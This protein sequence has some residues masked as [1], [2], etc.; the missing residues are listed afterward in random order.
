MF[1]RLIAAFVAMLVCTVSAS[2]AKDGSPPT[3]DLQKTCQAT[4]AAAAAVI[5]NT[6]QG[7][8]DVCMQ[9]ELAARMQIL[10]EWASFPALARSRCVKP[11][12][13]VPSYVEWVACLEM[14][15][16]VLKLRQERSSAPAAGLGK[17]FRE[18]PV[19]NVDQD[20]SINWV[21]ACRLPM[22]R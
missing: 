1:I 21:I 3:I 5:G 4:V 14:T 7:D 19:V 18:C 9:D 13:Y 20:G 17:N 2:L 10:N 12:E 15:R 6:G 22:E 11:Q 16:D 8:I